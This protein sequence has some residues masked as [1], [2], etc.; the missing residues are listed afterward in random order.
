MIKLSP[1]PN[2]VIGCDWQ[3]MTYERKITIR[4]KPISQATGKY[5]DENENEKA[6]KPKR[7]IIHL[8]SKYIGVIWIPAKN[9]WR[10]VYRKKY[11]GCFHDE[12]EAHKVY[13]KARGIDITEGIR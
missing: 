11:L 8:T 1:P 6:K 4:E 13:C 9:K 12:E 3:L 10:A 5:E 2:P 7:I